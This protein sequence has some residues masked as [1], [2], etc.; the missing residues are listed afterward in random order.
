MTSDDSEDQRIDDKEQARLIACDALL[1]AASTERETAFSDACS[2]EDRGRDRLRLL[3][4]MLEASEMVAD[5]EPV[6]ECVSP[7]QGRDDQPLLLG[8]F[9][10]LD[11]LGSGG[12]GFVVRARDRLLGREVALKMPLPERVLNPG[13]VHRFLRE[14]RSAARLDHP[15]IVRVHDAGELGPLGYFIASEYCEGP[16]LRRWLK[17]QNQP[18]PARLAARWVA[19]V[20]DAVQHAHDRGILHRDIKPDNILL[21]GGAKPEDLVP[22]LTDF[23]LAKVVEE[24]GDQ[25][26]SEARVGTP[27][28]MAP[29]QAAGRRS[30]VGPATDVY[31]LGATLYEILTGRPPFRGETEAETLRLVVESEPVAPRSLRPGLPR[32]LDTI[33]LKSLRKVPAYRYDSAAALHDDL[34]RFLNGRPIVGRPVSAWEQSC[35]WARQRPAVAALLGLVILLLGG[36]VGGIAAW[37]S[38]LEWHNLQLEIHIARGDQKAREAEEQT[39]IAEERRRQANRHHYAESLR[40]ARRALVDRQFELAQDILHDIQPEPD[41]FDPRGFAWRYLWR[42]AHREFSQLWGHEATVVGRSVARDGR[43]LVTWDLQGKA[44]LWHLSPDMELDRPRGLPAPPDAMWD[45]VWLSPDGRRLAALGRGVPNRRIDFFELASNQQVSRL[46]CNAGEE[47]HLL[48]FDARGGRA[49]VARTYPGV[50]QS[51]DSWDITTPSAHLVCKI[52]ESAHPFFQGFSADGSLLAVHQGEQFRL[53]DPWTGEDRVVLPVPQPGQVGPSSFSADGRYFAAQVPGNRISVWET[54]K[55]R[56]AARFESGGDAVQLTLSPKGSCVAVVDGSGRVTVLDRTSRQK[57]FLTQ[58]FANRAI[59]SQN[60]DFSP[61]E[62]RLAIGIATAPGGSQP[63]EV[64]DIAS[65]RRLHVFPGRNDVGSPAFLSDGRT[66][67]LAGGTTPRIW[68]LDAPKAP[69]A[70]AGHNDEAWTAAFSP[71]GKVLATGSDDTD[72]CQTIKL[73]DPNSGRLLSGWKAQFRHGRG[74]GVQ[75][76]WA[77]S[78]LSQPELRRAGV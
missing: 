28:Y 25:T 33:C 59:I 64:W 41:G 45:D 49:A 42:Q 76:G 7:S 66:L 50:R 5:H 23:G 34:E 27:V 38:W 20:A 22:R 46:N 73:W 24:A 67:I 31:G 71:D 26:L 75:P 8:R 30:E 61:D 32:D 57:R 44:L 18:V 37:A 48:C 65:A 70:L 77:A 72:E 54:A 52:L 60:M 15:N 2:P 1:R 78:R 6:A 62:R 14:A 47:L 69:D 74:A 68:R 16:S 19:A 35:V 4:R 12:F 36:L 53:L 55:G 56:E 29:E 51:A 17:S 9:E 10:V 39:R 43:T 13:D 3:L 63:V 11:H 21:A 58:G 40:R